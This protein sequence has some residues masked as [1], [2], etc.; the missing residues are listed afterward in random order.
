[1]QPTAFLIYNNLRIV[2]HYRLTSKLSVLNF[3]FIAKI[4]VIFKKLSDQ[5][6][7]KLDIIK[8]ISRQ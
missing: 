8:F 7:I 4:K 6:S 2:Y 3:H 1:M 5:L